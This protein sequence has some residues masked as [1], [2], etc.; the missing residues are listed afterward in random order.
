MK[1][2]LMIVIFNIVLIF[3]ASN[4]QAE[5]IASS[6]F[7]A[8][9][10]M[11]EQSNSGTTPETKKDISAES[12]SAV[13]SVFPYFLYGLFIVG[14]LAVLSIDTSGNARAKRKRSAL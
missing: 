9:Y 5:T 8:N 4:A 14:L 12:D 2:T 7:S 1:N 6:L 11:D 3:G 13:S 10:N